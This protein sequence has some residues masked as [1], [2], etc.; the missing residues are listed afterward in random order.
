MKC[1]ATAAA[2]MLAGA[3]SMFAQSPQQAPRGDQGPVILNLL[4]VIDNLD[5]AEEFYHRLLGLES[6]VGDPRARLEWYPESPFLDDIYR[7][8]GNSRN[9]V[10]RVPGSELGLEIEQFSGTKGKR[11][12]THLQDP[13]AQQ[14]IFTLNN[15]AA[16]NIDVLT[17]WLTKGGAKVLTAGGKPVSVKYGAGTARAILFED[18]NGL[19]VQLVQPDV[20]PPPRGINGAGPNSYITGATIAITVD[21]TEKTARYYREVLGVDVKT[22]SPFVADAKQMDV[23]GLKGAQYRESVV[24]LPEKSP[25]LHFLEFKGVDRKALRPEVADPNAVLVRFDIHDIAKFVTRVKAAGGEITNTSGAPSVNGKTL[26][27]VAK[28][29]NGVYSQFFERN[30]LP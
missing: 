19:F 7:T 11:L 12:N 22:D 28:D 25:Q 18:F 13:G 16:N 2:L 23:F 6:N 5:K 20:P 24:A 10:L 8:K 21:D 15:F 9:F 29:P 26:V 27:L 4:S 3:Y 1:V 30:I 14:L 17:G